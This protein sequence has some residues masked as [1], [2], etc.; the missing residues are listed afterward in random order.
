MHLWTIRKYHQQ[1][2]SRGSQARQTLGLRLKKTNV[3][4]MFVYLRPWGCDR[5][6]GFYIAVLYVSSF[7]Q[8]N[9]PIIK[10]TWA[11]SLFWLIL[12]RTLFS[13][14]RSGTEYFL[15]VMNCWFGPL[16]LCGLVFFTFIRQDEFTRQSQRGDGV[17]THQSRETPWQGKHK[18]TKWAFGPEPHYPDAWWTAK[19][20]APPHADHWGATRRQLGVWLA[21]A[22]IFWTWFGGELLC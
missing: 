14:N 16:G 7:L 8:L 10:C 11:L 12:L 15:K 20:A 19:A 13:Y 18:N 3:Q 17:L 1:D 21:T 5:V 2:S 6:Y 4:I 9:G 22:Q